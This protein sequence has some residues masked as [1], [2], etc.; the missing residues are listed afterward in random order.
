MAYEMNSPSQQ[1]V[2]GLPAN[3]SGEMLHRQEP[4]HRTEC[5]VSPRVRHADVRTF[6][7]LNT[8]DWR[9]TQQ[10]WGSMTPD[11]GR[12]ARENLSTASAHRSSS[13]G[14]LRE[15][16]LLSMKERVAFFE[17]RLSRHQARMEAEAQSLTRQQRTSQRHGMLW[18]SRRGPLRLEAIYKIK[19]PLI[20]D[21]SGTPWGRAPIIG[22]GKPE[23]QNHAIAFSRMDTMQVM[24]MNMESYLEEA[25]KLRNLLQ[26]FVLNARMR[27]LGFREHIFTENVSSLA[28]YMALQE[29]LFTTTN[30]R[31]Y[32][33]PL[34][35]RMHY[36]HPDIFDRY[37]VQTCGSCSKASNGINLSEDIFAGFNCTARGYCVHHAD[38]IQCG[39]GRDVGLQQVVM[40]EKKVAGGNGEQVLSRDLNRLVLN[41]DFFRLLSLWFTGPGF[42]LNSVILVLAAY[43]CLYTKCFLAFAKY[44]YSGPV[45]SALEYVLTPSTYI[46]FQLGMLLVLP[47]IPWLFLEKGLVSAVRKLIDLFS[48]FSV[49]Y[50][51]FM[52]CTKASVIDHVLIYGGAKYQETG[53]GFVIERATLKDIWMFFYFTHFSIGMEMF[54]LLAVYSKYAGLDASVF[55]LDTWPILLMA[56]SINS[57]PFIFNPLGFYYPRLRQDFR[58]WNAWMASRELGLP[59]KSWV[60]WWRGEM[61]QRCNLVWHHKVILV[62]RLLRFP[63][64]AAG[65]VSCVATSI[66]SADV[67]CAMY[68]MAASGLFVTMKAFLGDLQIVSPSA[69]AWL[70]LILVTGVATLICWLVFTSKISLGSLTVSC[71]ALCLFIYG[72]L[73]IVFAL[74]GRWAVRSDMLSDVIREYHRCAGLCTFAPLLVL[75]AVTTSVHHLQTRILFNPTFVSIVKS[76]LVQREQVEKSGHG[77]S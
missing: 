3:P 75:S 71:F 6:G 21:E 72:M 1:V 40:F 19:L 60:S 47:L 22:P 49:T 31:L 13:L 63:L 8:P 36:G 51:N 42:F 53:R 66:Q 73:E 34:R 5:Q 39:K 4:T 57:V 7:R 38:Y 43:V 67:D 28:S 29:N 33:T 27:I 23:N 26:E 74:L 61:E 25:I 35:V 52:T 20:M 56:V 11:H 9:G 2:V 10:L 12:E 15:R 16:G 45:E 59:K 62:L 44:N 30:Q 55:F 17:G 76:G 58:N 24:D 41:M 65:I 37:F 64:L 77:H 48:K 46:Q 32:F 14:A 50:Y 70:S 69:K 68:L 54:V 18:P